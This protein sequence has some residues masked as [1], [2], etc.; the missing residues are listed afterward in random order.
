MNIGIIGAGFAGLA[1]ARVLRALGHQVTV[2]EK[3][4]DV[5]GVWSATRR[6]PGLRT[7][8]NKGSYSLSDMAMPR[9][10][11]QWPTS[12]Q[13]QQYLEGYAA[14]FDLPG[15][16]RLSTEVTAAVPTV[17]GGWDVTARA[18]D[19]GENT[20]HFDHLVVASGIFSRPFIPDYEGVDDLERAGGRVIPANELQSLDQVRGKHAV[21]VGYGKS[22]CDIAVETAAVARSTTVVARHLLW[23]MP[24]HVKGIIN[25]KYL[26]LTRLGESLFPYR[27]LTGFERFLHARGSAVANGMLGGVEKITTGQLRLKPLGLLPPGTFA[28]IARSTVS[29]ASE[30]FFEAVAEGRITVQRDTRIVRFLEKDGAPHAELANGDVLR[31]DLVLAATGWTQEIPFL[32]PSVMERLVDDNGDFLLYRQI[33]PIHVDDLSFAGY[34]SSFLSPLSAEVSAIWIG[35]LLGGNHRTPSREEMLDETRERLAWMRERTRG[36]HAHG[37]NLIPFSVHNID[38]VLSDVGLDVS[39]AVKIKQW[40]LP[41]NPQDYRHITP[42]LAKTLQEAA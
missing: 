12:A 17:G 13:V 27:R 24:R 28:D 4:P 39:R 37:T 38:E 2:Y 19:G 32:P 34:N 30:G 36:K 33:H 5:G 16:L 9:S 22:A 7:Q 18:A 41:F 20:T 25:Y 35:S 14:E 6:Y 8:N 15:C 10:F 42:R 26:L 40:L 3:E 31:A 11:P 23:K 29:L 1:S 21:I